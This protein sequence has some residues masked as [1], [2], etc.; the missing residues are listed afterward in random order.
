VSD[1]AAAEPSRR[2]VLQWE[3]LSF[4]HLLQVSLGVAVAIALLRLSAI[5]EGDPQLAAAILAAAGYIGPLAQMVLV[6][7]PTFVIISAA[8]VLHYRRLARRAGRSDL[9]TRYGWLLLV[10]AAVLLAFITPWIVLLVGVITVAAVLIPSAIA[11]RRR[12]RRGEELSD[13]DFRRIV[14]RQ[15]VIIVSIVLSFTVLG[16]IADSR[17]WLPEEKVATARETV[18]GFVLSVT[19]EWTT[20]LVDNPRYLAYLRTDDVVSRTTCNETW[21]QTLYQV[22]PVAAEDSLPPPGC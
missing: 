19:S 9:V 18:D 13:E 15:L 22:L 3:P 17:P 1:E 8:Y 7:V 16:T 14:R 5:A 12:R 6:F 4:P 10:W 2:R 21:N 20:V 11:E